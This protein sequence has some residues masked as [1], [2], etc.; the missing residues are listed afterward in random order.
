[1]ATNVTIDMGGTEKGAWC[2]RTG[3]IDWTAS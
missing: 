1:M 2:R 3:R